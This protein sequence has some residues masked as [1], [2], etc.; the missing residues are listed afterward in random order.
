MADTSKPFDDSKSIFHSHLAEKKM[1]YSLNELAAE[2]PGQHTDWTIP[3]AFLCLILSVAFADGNVSL[4]EQEEIRAIAHRSRTL[5]GMS[6]NEL[7]AANKTILERRDNRPNWLD[8]A[9]S[10]LPSDMHLSVFALCLDI[11]LADSVLLP[12]EAEFLQELLSRLH[13]TEEEAQ[14]LTKVIAAKNRF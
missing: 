11:A 7:A 8:E 5:K 12:T 9:C 6:Q 2:F 13:I 10:A 4:E 14:L 3:E 1:P